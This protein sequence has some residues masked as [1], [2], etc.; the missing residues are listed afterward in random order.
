MPFNPPPTLATVRQAVAIRLNAGGQ[1]DADPTFRQLLDELIRRSVAEILRE[2]DWAELRERWDVALVNDQSIYDFPADLDPGRIECITIVDTNNAEFELKPGIAF[3][4]RDALAR[5]SPTLPSRYEVANSELVILPAPEVAKYPTMRIE[6]YTRPAEVFNNS[7]R[8]P[9]Q[10]EVVVQW[11]AALG[12]EHFGH[13][14]WQQAKADAR[15]YAKRLRP[16]QSDGETLQLGGRFAN[17]GRYRQR[18]R[19]GTLPPNYWLL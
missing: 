16:A 12:K 8:V 4:E 6:A 11:A 3:Y 5:M 14:N 15:E 18:R 1:A 10:R 7:E 2:A 17:A 9:V 13:P 19:T